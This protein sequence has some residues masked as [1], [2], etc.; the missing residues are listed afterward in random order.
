MR[1]RS[2]PCCKRRMS[3]LPVHSRG[4]AVYLGLLGFF[5]D[6]RKWILKH[7]A[8]GLSQST[9]LIF[10]MI[11]AIAV[12]GYFYVYPPNDAFTTQVQIPYLKNVFWNLNH[13]LRPV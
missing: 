8:R 1:K 7:P 13:E 5:D 11:W 3:P 4:S 2:A 9:K 12:T 10:Q 6:Y